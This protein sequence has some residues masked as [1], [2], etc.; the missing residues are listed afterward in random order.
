MNVVLNTLGSNSNF[1]I[2]MIYAVEH[3]LMQLKVFD[4]SSANLQV[5][6]IFLI[7][8]SDNI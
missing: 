6:I 8:P 1:C 4:F 5:D 7:S 3:C 2:N